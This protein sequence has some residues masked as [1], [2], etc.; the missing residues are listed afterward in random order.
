M[1][2]PVGVLE[3]EG[4]KL[5]ASAKK[6][7]RSMVPIVMKHLPELGKIPSGYDNLIGEVA[8]HRPSGKDD[9]PAMLII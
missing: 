6:D 5:S 2:D 1:K 7:L 3:N 4:V 9:D 8:G